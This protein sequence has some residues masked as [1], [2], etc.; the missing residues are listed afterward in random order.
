[1]VCKLTTMNVAN[2]IKKQKK[3]EKE[4]EKRGGSPASPQLVLRAK[5]KRMWR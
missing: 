5:R 4:G 1:M 3:K 2:I